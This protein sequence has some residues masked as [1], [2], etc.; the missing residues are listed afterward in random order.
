VCVFVKGKGRGGREGEP[1]PPPPLPPPPPPFHRPNPACSAELS[2]GEFF[3]LQHFK[4][5]FTIF[6]KNT[7]NATESL[8]IMF[9]T[10]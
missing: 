8:T 6:I 5:T 3:N 2:E 4:K 10:I 7:K 1:P 9:K